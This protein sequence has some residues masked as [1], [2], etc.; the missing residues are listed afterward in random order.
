MADQ[1][2]VLDVKSI[3]TD[4]AT[5]SGQAELPHLDVVERRD[6]VREPGRGR[7]RTEEPQ[8][9]QGEIR[10]ELPEDVLEESHAARLIWAVLGTLD[11][12]ALT[13]DAKAVEGGSGRSVK[14]P[15]MMLTLWLYAISRGIGSAREIRRLT[16][17]DLAYQWIVGGVVVSH[18]V[19][20]AFRASRGKAFDQLMTDVLACL[21]H[22]GLI[23]LDLVAQDGTRTRASASAPSFRTMG[24]LLQCRQQAELHLKAVLADAD[25]PEHTRAVH[26]RREAAARDFQDR[27]NAAIETARELQSERSSMERPARASTTDHEARVMKM[28]DGGF[29]PAYNVAYGVAGSP[30]GGP[31]TIVGVI[32]NNVGSDMG[33]LTPMVEQIHQRTDQ[34]PKVLLADGG[35]AKHEDIV[36]AMRL[37]VDVIVPPKDNAKPIEQL[38]NVPSEVLDWRH[39][40]ETD[41]AQRLYRARAGLCE[42]ANAHQKGTQGLTQVVVRGL[43]KVTN[44]VMLGAISANILAHAT[45][46]LTR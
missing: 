33:S 23:S 11:L 15:R 7:V 1:Q 12:S 22:K 41:E 3:K 8:R 16:S 20:S 36:E 37:G 44:V 5:S 46:L 19:I 13:E 17:T 4:Q 38:G 9:R 21:L 27:V 2:P 26:A 42:L 32:V 39:R 14:S 28:G 6:P 34:R 30:L 35:H 45:N 31:R 29:R 40:M 43:T 25:N 24:S 10:F 18:H